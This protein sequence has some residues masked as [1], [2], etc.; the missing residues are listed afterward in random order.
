MTDPRNAWQNEAISGFCN[1]SGDFLVTATPG[2][3][4]TLMAMKAAKILHNEGLIDRIIVVVPNSEVKKQ[5]RKTAANLGLDI[6]ADFKNENGRLPDDVDGAVATYAQVANGK[7]IWRK[8]SSKPHRSLVIFDEIHHC[9]DEDNSAWGP[10]IRDAFDQVTRRLLLSGTPFRTDGN[11]IPFVKYDDSGRA[12]SDGGISYKRAIIESVVRPVRFPIMDGEGNYLRGT[13]FI[14]ATAST[15]DKNQQAALMRTL[16]QEHESWMTSLM[17]DA[18][19]ELTR[20]RDEKPTAAGLIVASDIQ[21]AEA[22]KVMIEKITGQKASVVHSKDET[23]NRTIETFRT[24]TQRWIVA[25]DM[26]SEGVDIP[27]LSII[28]YASNKTTDMWFRQIVGRAVRRDNDSLT[29]TVYI[30]A[31]PE[32]VKLAKNIEDEVDL[33]LGI[34]VGQLELMSKAEAR[35]FDIQIV[36]P[37]STSSIIQN[38]VLTPG[39]VTISDAELSQALSY[40]QRIEGLK[41]SHVSDIAL[42]I[43]EVGKT[44]AITVAHAQLPATTT[45]ND[46]LREAKKHT[47]NTLVNKIQGLT[48]EHFGQIHGNLNR[49]YGDKLGNASLETLDKRIQELQSWL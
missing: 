35:D 45:T 29:A 47:V 19:N 30:G 3:G 32:L 4:K 49:K 27:R 39:G 1:S 22:Y 33:A 17:T 48:G 25:V 10:S 6:T 13:S 28:V 20:M 23:S 42:L 14:S 43:R 31:F 24:S 46:A 40:Q 5:W 18:D 8:L 38:S 7:D 11:P 16:Y 9:Q 36:Q 41:S 26:I 34:K 44:T 15:V 2:A 21:K 12:I 37:I